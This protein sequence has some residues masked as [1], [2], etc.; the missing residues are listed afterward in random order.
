MKQ[1]NKDYEQ[2]DNNF[3]YI[4][5]VL[6][7]LL[8]ILNNVGKFSNIRS[9]IDY[10]FSPVTNSANKAG[11]SV[12][13]YFS[14]FIQ[15]GNFRKEYNSMKT[16]IAENDAKYSNY[17]VL[18]NE[19]EALK[20]QLGVEN[21]DAKL[22]MTN[23]LRDDDINSLLID[24]GSDSGVKQGDVVV[25]G[26]TFIGIVTVADR[27]GSRVRLAT[28][29]SSHLQVVV[30]KDNDQNKKNIVSNGVV[31]GSTEGIKIE[32]IDMN[33]DV[34]DGDVVYVND[35]K[36]GGFWTLGYIVGLSKNPANTYK[37][38]YVSPVLD[39]DDLVTVFVKLN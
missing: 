2:K 18:K 22:V 20:Q 21:N 12:S 9:S 4:S 19:N 29:N 13:E 16:Q 34:A 33:S 1:G 24:E 15:L 8:L 6:G 17:L 10:V 30:M 27:N 35:S 26:N 11:E 37:T 7:I 25:L 23:V 28:D 38:A 39:Y 36:I 31:S 14:T 32:N 3:V 5:F